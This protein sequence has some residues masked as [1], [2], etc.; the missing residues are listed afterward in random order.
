MILIAWLELLCVLI[1][2]DRGINRGED[3]IYRR[4]LHVVEGLAYERIGS[5]E[6]GAN[7]PRM[8]WDG[9]KLQDITST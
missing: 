8:S 9:I 6:C 1:S 3:R 2:R 5:F 4:M 7:C